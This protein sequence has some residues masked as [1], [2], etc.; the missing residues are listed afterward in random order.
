MCV[1]VYFNS[2]NQ[3]FGRPHSSWQGEAS[4]VCV[5]LLLKPLAESFQSS[6]T[7]LRFCCWSVQAGGNGFTPP[8]LVLFESVP[9]SW[10]QTDWCQLGRWYFQH[11]RVFQCKRKC[12]SILHH[13]SKAWNGNLR[14]W[15]WNRTAGRT[16]KDD[17]KHYKT[18]STKSYLMFMC[19]FST[20]W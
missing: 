7:V 19:F 1:C 10:C 16:V 8:N 9:L 15:K 5:G 12:V 17:M 14:C 20:L 13:E 11:L 4:A 3:E 6:A 2:P 18:G